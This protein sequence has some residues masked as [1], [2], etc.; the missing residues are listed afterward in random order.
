MQNLA[1]KAYHQIEF[2]HHQTLHE[3]LTLSLQVLTGNVPSFSLSKIDGE[4]LKL[5]M[6]QTLWRLENPCKAVICECIFVILPKSPTSGVPENL[7]GLSFGA[8]QT[9][10]LTSM[11][12]LTAF[13]YIS[14]NSA[15]IMFSFNHLLI[16]IKN[17]MRTEM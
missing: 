11:V 17:T 1:G 8:A 15:V 4:G 14:K 10:T 6:G 12:K 5:N 9:G 3:I 16:A 13:D 2:P 7:R